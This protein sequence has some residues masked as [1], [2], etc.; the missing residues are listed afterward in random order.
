MEITKTGFL[1]KRE[2]KEKIRLDDHQSCV[3]QTFQRSK[4]VKCSIKI[5]IQKSEC[6]HKIY[7][8]SS[9]EFIIGY[10]CSLSH[11]HMSMHALSTC[12]HPPVLL[13]MVLTVVVV[14]GGELV[15]LLPAVALPSS[16]SCEQPFSMA[17]T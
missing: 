3:L 6:I 17:R 10:V 14:R 2:R 5:F 13:W 4:Q 11:E 1:Q 8:L 16:S 15:L 12:S 9:Y 7:F